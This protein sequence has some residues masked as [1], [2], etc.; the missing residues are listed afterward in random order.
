MFSTCPAGLS[1]GWQN[2]WGLEGL[3]FSGFSLYLSQFEMEYKAVRRQCT[4]LV[5]GLA[6]RALVYLFELAC[7]TFSVF[8]PTK[9]VFWFLE[10][11]F[12][13]EFELPHLAP[14]FSHGEGLGL[15]LAFAAS[16]SKLG[17]TE[18]GESKLG[19]WICKVLRSCPRERSGGAPAGAR[20]PLCAR[21]LGKME[22]DA[23][24]EQQT[25]SCQSASS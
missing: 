17:S 22:A 9:R 15:T 3:V 4:T 11:Q 5:L 8:S 7:M 20:R 16:V 25:P 18:V 19:T 12:L 13:S 14:D 2:P 23:T 1:Q 24:A 21:S 10:E 6:E